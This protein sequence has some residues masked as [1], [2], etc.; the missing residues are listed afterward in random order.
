[1]LAIS[2]RL[3]PISLRH[4]SNRPTQSEK[5]P[6]FAT[7]PGIAVKTLNHREHRVSPRETQRFHHPSPPLWR[8]F[9]RLRALCGDVFV[10]LANPRKILR[11]ARRSA[12]LLPRSR[13]A[14]ALTSL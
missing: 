7:L 9:V 11:Y 14:N 13:R 2:S 6:I 8:S 4:S 10:T 5:V 12:R 3:T 1:K